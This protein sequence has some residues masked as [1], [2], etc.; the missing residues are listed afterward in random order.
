MA[1]ADQDAVTAARHGNPPVDAKLGSLYTFA[2]RIIGHRGHVTPEDIQEVLDSG[3]TR[4]AVLE[5]IAQIGHT[6]IANFTHNVSDV[7]P[8]DAFE[9][10]VWARA[11]A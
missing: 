8:D 3:Y 1:G 10:Q 2:R 6:T 4:A 5:G 7:R 11:A 9:P